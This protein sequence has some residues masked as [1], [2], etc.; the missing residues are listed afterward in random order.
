MRSNILNLTPQ[1]NTLESSK[2][3]NRQSN[4]SLSVKQI[5]SVPERDVM[6]LINT[7]TSLY[8][9]A[10][11]KKEDISRLTLQL[12]RLLNQQEASSVRQTTDSNSSAQQLTSK[13]PESTSQLKMDSHK[14]QG[15]MEM[16]RTNLLKEIQAFRSRNGLQKKQS[17]GKT[18]MAVPAQTASTSQ[19][20]ANTVPLKT[21]KSLPSIDSL[22]DKQQ[23][24]QA[25]PPPPPPPPPPASFS[26]K[27]IPT[28]TSPTDSSKMF[29]QIRQFGRTK[30]LKA[31]NQGANTN[32]P[33]KSNPELSQG[34]KLIFEEPENVLSQYQTLTDDD[35]DLVARFISQAIIHSVDLD[36]LGQLN[37]NIGDLQADQVTQ[38]HIDKMPNYCQSFFNVI[39]PYTKDTES[40][41][42]FSHSMFKKSDVIAGNYQPVNIDEEMTKGDE[43]SNANSSPSQWLTVREGLSKMQKQ[44]SITSR[45]RYDNGSVASTTE[46]TSE[47]FAKAQQASLALINDSTRTDLLSKDYQSQV[48]GSFKNINTFSG[49]LANLDKSAAHKL[50]SEFRQAIQSPEKLEESITN[51]LKQRLPTGFKEFTYQSINE[52]NQRLKAELALLKKGNL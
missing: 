20:L 46:K 30:G 43:M 18:E 6:K 47:V 19:H 49:F 24:T 50:E 21:G 23:T 7:I 41:P 12:D 26:G 14:A 3:P 48:T 38:A 32:Q 34:Q 4:D 11:V 17:S 10:Q 8:S 51:F 13:S 9:Q 40:A 52:E 5:S 31:L 27:A 28:S 44:L 36:V 37:N 22:Q 2:Q 15:T 45:K 1:P 16:P 42:L 29:E 35:K 33:V 25:A 39:K